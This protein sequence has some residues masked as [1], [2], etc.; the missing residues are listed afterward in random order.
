VGTGVAV[1]RHL[2]QGAATSRNQHFNDLPA[3]TE[4]RTPHTPQPAAAPST[5]DAVALVHD[6]HAAIRTAFDAL[7]AALH[8]E[9]SEADRQGL[10]ARVAL[11]L[12]AHGQIERECL[13]PVL[14]G[15]AAERAPAEAEH[16]GF[17][18]A[19][20]ALAAVTP[21]TAERNQALQALA[22]EVQCH[23]AEEEATLRAYADGV[24][25]GV[26]LLALG[27]QMALRRGELLADLGMD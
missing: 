2:L 1:D 4:A 16:A 9:A 25:P 14:H 22:V 21:P 7:L 27:T 23:A 5:Q 13:Y 18:S 15:V 26:D 6:D 19:L 20:E 8:G 10:L 24:G 12:R 3:M 11:R 17:E